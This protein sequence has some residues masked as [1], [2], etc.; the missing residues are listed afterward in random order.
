[1]GGIGEGSF[2]TQIVQYPTRQL[3][4]F[5]PP[6]LR[7]LAFRLRERL[8]AVLPEFLVGEPVALQFARK[9]IATDAQ[10][11]GGFA[12]IARTLL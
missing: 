7:F 5:V 11:P 1:M 6:L 2:R 3:L 4:H 9:G 12:T 10:L 8:I